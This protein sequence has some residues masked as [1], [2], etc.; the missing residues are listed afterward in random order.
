MGLQT[1]HS[2]AIVLYTRISTKFLGVTKSKRKV[3]GPKQKQR[4]AA[5]IIDTAFQGVFSGLIEQ[6]E[7][8]EQTKAAPVR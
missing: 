3:I 7:K 8:A 2:V 5:S 1:F 4:R 6:P